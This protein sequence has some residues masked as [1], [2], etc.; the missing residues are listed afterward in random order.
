MKDVLIPPSRVLEGTWE[1]VSR[2]ASSLTGKRVRVT[3]LE[4][5][6]QELTLEEQERLLDELAAINAHLPP[7]P[8]EAMTRA[9]IYDDHD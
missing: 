6:P 2:E 9:A 7:L 1:E 5:G 4:D 3:V 8:E